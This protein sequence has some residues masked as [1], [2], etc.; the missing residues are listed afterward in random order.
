MCI[1]RVYPFGPALPTPDD[2][3]IMGLTLSIMGSSA[4]LPVLRR[5][6][7]HPID[8]GEFLEIFKAL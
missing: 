5:L 8:P 4:I 7:Y 1:I 2:R 6:V 3:V